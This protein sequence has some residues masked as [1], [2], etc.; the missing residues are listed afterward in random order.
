[1]LRNRSACS[2]YAS[3]FRPEWLALLLCIPFA[4]LAAADNLQAAHR[5]A[6]LSSELSV[7]TVGL[8]LVT[9][10]VLTLA[11]FFV[12][13]WTWGRMVRREPHNTLLQAACI[14]SIGFGGLTLAPAGLFTWYVCGG[15]TDGLTVERVVQFLLL[16]LGSPGLVYYTAFRFRRVALIRVMAHAV[17][18]TLICMAFH[19]LLPLNGPAGHF[20]AT[21]YALLW[22]G[23]FMVFNSWEA[24]GWAFV[25]R[26]PS[27]D[28]I[29]AWARR[30]THEHRNLFWP[31]IGLWHF[32]FVMGEVVLLNYALAYVP[33]MAQVAPLISTYGHWVDRVGPVE[34]AVYA[35]VIM[36]TAL[37]SVFIE[38]MGQT[39]DV[40]D[41]ALTGQSVLADNLRISDARYAAMLQ[42]APFAVF[43]YD[44]QLQVESE[45]P[46][47]T[48]LFESLSQKRLA[49]DAN[50]PLS[51]SFRTTCRRVFDGR[52]T[53]VEGFLD[54][55]H[56]AN[57]RW[58]RLTCE[59]VLSANGDCIAGIGV[60]DDQTERNLRE[61]ELQRLTTEAQAAREL[62]Q[63]ASLAKSRFLANMSHEIRTPMNGLFGSIQLLSDSRLAD[64]KRVRI[65][66][67]M[68]RSADSMIKLLNDI[69]DLSKIEAGA[70][71]LNIRPVHLRHL[72]EDA[73]NLFQAAADAK[74]LT[75]RL[76]CQLPED[77]LRVQG[78]ELRLQQ[79]LS[80]LIGNAVKF[81]QQGHITLTLERE[82]APAPDVQRIRFSVSDTGPGIAALEL[83]HLF[84]A[85]YQL[86]NQQTGTNEQHTP[87]GSGLGLTIVR[88]LAE[89]MEGSVGVTSRLGEGSV[90]WFAVNLNA[91]STPLATPQPH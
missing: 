16:T 29:R 49:P 76:D 39:R 84:D 69:L 51:Q 15:Y 17:F 65:L 46:A 41:E 20:E 68:R 71:Q 77:V 42:Q 5:I 52:R 88:S 27:H 70:M 19:L 6:P 26:V 86:E 87:K 45:N 33:D 72:G 44:A 61:T 74:Q 79:M 31:M 82:A 23:L 67:T 32:Y 83:R 38:T 90:F 12:S 35:T 14:F 43:Q 50:L 10:E 63:N 1:M 47:A 13:A 64:E 30:F 62:A 36:G 80:N 66:Q 9:F 75:L 37:I 53:S 22:L 7:A 58:F 21:L 60:L 81:T 91:D 8:M 3:G 28:G 85:Y 57:R 34:S 24:H 18:T 40:R 54:P 25:E 56:T 78:D 2:R 89:R 73:L 4:A 11:S 48:A 55:P 59:P